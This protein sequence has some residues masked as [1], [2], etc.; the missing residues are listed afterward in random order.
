MFILFKIIELEL[1]AAHEGCPKR[2]YDTLSAFS[3]QDT[4]GVILFGVDEITERPCYYGGVGRMKGSYIRS[5]DS[6]E[7][8]SDYEI[9]GKAFG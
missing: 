5:G 8:M 9:F 3:N 7:P 6:D 2:L 4:G 1:K